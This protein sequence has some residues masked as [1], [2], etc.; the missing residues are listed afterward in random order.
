[1]RDIGAIMREMD[2]INEQLAVEL[3]LQGRTMPSSEVQLEKGAVES[4]TD[5][6]KRIFE[7]KKDSRA[8]LQSYG[9]GA[10]PKTEPKQEQSSLDPCSNII[11]FCCLKEFPEGLTVTF[12]RDFRAVYDPGNLRCVVEELTAPVMTPSSC[13]PVNARLYAVR[14]IGCM[15]VSFSIFAFTSRCG[16]DFVNPV[17]EP[18]VS[19]SC[20]DN[21][22]VDN[23][24]CYRSTR[25]QAEAACEAIREALDSNPCEAVSIL[26]IRVQLLQVFFGECTFRKRILGFTGNFELPIC[27]LL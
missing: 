25:A 7:Y 1:M 15:P 2:K 10:A 8:N 4:I 27:P 21:L 16:V 24:L 18:G 5:D 26:N 3:N 12:T 13:D 22:C 6:G 11:P 9:C 17:T 14:I 19:L 23:V 20:S